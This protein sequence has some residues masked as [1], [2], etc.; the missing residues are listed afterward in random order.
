Q[1]L[2]HEMNAAGYHTA[3][4]GKWHLRAPP[5]SFDYYCVLPGQGDYFDPVFRIQGPGFWEDN[6]IQIKGK[7]SSDAIAD[8]GIEWL[9]KGWNREQPFFLM[10]HF[11]APHDMFDNAPRYDSYLDNVEIPEPANMRTPPPSGMGSGI[12]KDHDNWRLG[13]RL[14]SVDLSL[15]EPEYGRQVYQHFLKRYLRCVKGVDDNVGRLLEYLREIGELDNTIILYTGDQGYFLGEHNLMDKRWMYE[16]AFRMPLLVQAPGLV[17]PGGTNNWLIN[18]TDFAPTLLELAGVSTPE[19]MQGR[20]F[21][22][23]L[24]GKEKPDDWRTSLYYR[25][26][27]HMAHNLRVPAHFGIRTD[28]YKLIFFYGVDFTKKFPPTSPYWEFYDLEK[29]PAENVNQYE[30]PEYREIIDGLKKELKQIRIDLDET[31]DAYPEIQAVIDAHWNDVEPTN[32]SLVYPG[33]D[34]R[35]EYRP[36]TKQGDKIIDYSYCGYKRSEEPIPDVPE[37]ETLSPLPGKAVPEKDMAYPNGPDS[38][39][40]IQAALDRVA[41]MQADTNSGFRGAVLLKKGTYYV[42]GEL[43]VDSGVVLRGEGDDEDGTVLIFRNPKGTGISVGRGVKTE[44]L[45]ADSEIRDRYVPAGSTSVTL[46]HA[47]NFKPGDMILITKV[48]NDDWIETLGMDK[49]PESEGR[50]WKP[51]GYQLKHVRMVT[52]VEGNTITLDVPLPQSF[53]EDHC[54]GTVQA[55]D[56]S[57]SSKLC[58]VEGLRIISNYDTSVKS[59]LRAYDGPYLADEEEN[60]ACGVKLKCI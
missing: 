3:M 29:D 46:R 34:G 14:G 4:I 27:M 5:S 37:V 13:E 58:G 19:Y 52:D 12:T 9:S 49:I 28:R 60:L 43:S 47:E 36:Y 16:E 31:D 24:K 22:P 23:A 15:E 21:V 20:S 53:D 45:D 17:A 40:Q 33:E 26:W 54:V 32:S 10:Q 42:N 44:R 41:A 55:V 39:E 2:A 18:N 6:T 59:D 56:L 11:K 57:G 51:D 30:H 35:L 1:Y 50:P 48:T 38:R 7:H 25:Y 8:I